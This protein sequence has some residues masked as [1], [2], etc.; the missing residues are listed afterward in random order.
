MTWRT[1]SCLRRVWHNRDYD[2][3]ESILSPRSYGTTR[4]M[5]WNASPRFG[6]RLAQQ[7]VLN[8]AWHSKKYESGAIIL[9]FFV[10][11]CLTYLH[12]RLGQLPIRLGSAWTCGQDEGTFMDDA[13]CPDRSLVYPLHK[14]LFSFK[15][16]GA[17][18]AL[19]KTSGPAFGVH[20][21]YH[22]KKS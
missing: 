15:R 20:V 11:S 14:K 3:V 12:T 4:S 21:R 8:Y 16:K 17:S 2:L 5:A 13:L 10:L 1:S 19:F 6:M 22:G 7:G 9:S 18:N